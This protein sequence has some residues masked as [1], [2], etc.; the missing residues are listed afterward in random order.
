[1]DMYVLNIMHV[2]ELAPASTNQYWYNSAS[3]FDIAE[4]TSKYS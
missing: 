2:Q 3:W 1:M 4:A